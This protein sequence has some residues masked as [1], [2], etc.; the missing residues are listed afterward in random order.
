MKLCV[1]VKWVLYTG[2]PFEIDEKNCVGRQKNSEP[3]YTINRPDRSA[4][5]VA[6]QLRNAIGGEI[7]AVTLG[8]PMANEA[9]YTCLGRGADNGIHIINDEFKSHDSYVTALC[10]SRLVRS[11]NCD[12]ILCGGRSYDSNNFQVPY[13]LAE[14]LNLPQISRVIK[15]EYGF[16]AMKIRATRR[17]RRG[18]REIIESS[19]P[20][21]ITVEA[22]IA[23]PH[24]VSMRS[25]QIA[26]E[27]GIR[28][29]SAASLF[30]NGE[31]PSPLV[32]EIRQSLPRPRPKATATPDFKATPAQ[33]LRFIMS[34]GIETKESTELL[35]GDSGKTLEILIDILKRERVI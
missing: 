24:Y 22:A 6:I 23:E 19:L 8:P 1:C 15:L 9:L 3:I 31:W 7:F 25:E 34:G 14:T 28:S 4:L 32:R 33:R 2:I 11:L 35:Q 21:V 27:R 16:E 30:D 18:K 5:E 29:L 26:A 12:L 20:S 13:F 17:L 10:L